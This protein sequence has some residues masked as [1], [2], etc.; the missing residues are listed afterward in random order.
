[1]GSIIVL[2]D[3]GVDIDVGVRSTK[4]DVEITVCGILQMNDSN[5]LELLTLLAL[6]ALKEAH[7]DTVLEFTCT[8][9]LH[10]IIVV[11]FG[12]VQTIAIEEPRLVGE[13]TVSE[14]ELLIIVG[15][16]ILHNQ[17]RRDR[18]LVVGNKLGV[19]DAF[20]LTTAFLFRSVT[21]GFPSTNAVQ[22][23]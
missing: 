12:M 14:N 1:M 11:K 10:A 23:R 4:F 20:K 5:A 13:V 9:R 8:T 18:I 6:V 7:V 15:N 17:T 22:S 3:D 19:I 16:G 21:E 2:Q